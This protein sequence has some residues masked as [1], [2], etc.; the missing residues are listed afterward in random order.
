MEGKF[1]DLSDLVLWRLQFLAYY[2][3]VDCVGGLERIIQSENCWLL[4]CGWAGAGAADDR[5]LSGAAAS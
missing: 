2:C 3:G 4:I 1:I 5:P